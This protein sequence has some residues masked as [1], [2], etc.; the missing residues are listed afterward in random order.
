MTKFFTF[1]LTKIPFSVEFLP[2]KLI[3]LGKSL[4]FALDRQLKRIGR[5]VYKMFWTVRTKT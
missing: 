1:P 3:F 4:G 2:Y 5:K